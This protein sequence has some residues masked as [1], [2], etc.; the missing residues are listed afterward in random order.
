M[1]HA[2]Q[3][4][5]QNHYELYRYSKWLFNKNNIR[6]SV[7]FIY[8]IIV[9]LIGTLFR[10]NGSL[11]CLLVTVCFAIYLLYAETKKTYIKD[12]VVTARVKRQIV[13]LGL[14]MIAYIALAMHFMKEDLLGISVIAL[15]YLLIYPMA[16][17]TMPMEYLIKKHYENEARAIL[18]SQDD[19]LKIGI[20]GSY[21][22]TSTKNIINDIISYDRYTLMTPASYNTPMGITRTIRE[23]LKPIHEIFLCEMGADKVGDIS[24]LMDFVKP[25]YG[26]VTSIGKQHLNTFHDLEN[27]IYEK[28]QEVELLPPDGIAFLNA[29][30]E[31][32]RSYKIRN[33]CKVITVATADIEADYVA[34][35]LRYTKDGS[36]FTVKI[37][38]HNYKFTTSLLG[39]HNI[40]NILLGIAVAIELGMDLRTIQQRVRNVRQV[41]H[42]LQI[43]KISN[44]TF[45][46]DA[47]NANP[48]GSKNALDVLSMMPGKR[49]I[50]TP[51]MI[52][53]GTIQYDANK[54]F[55]KYMPGKADEVILVGEKQTEPIYA[56]LKEAAFDLAHVHVF[57]TVNEALTYVYKNFSSADTILLE[58][59]LPDAFNV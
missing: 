52:D 20:T 56:G 57:K 34:K 47:F 25:Q 14:L 12:L 50:V 22:K 31:Y 19:L 17:L 5:Q 21:G 28:M 9:L 37:N 13:V 15:S 43:K 35:D 39:K 33:R 11:L 24:Y 16:L 29:D 46:D 59:D 42:R 18:N 7:T 30:N 4:F 10:K 54:E 26:I 40:T 44:L 8:I 1:K 2:L 38:N 36:T 48:E 55:G 6:L 3:M 32:I 23:E 41:E 27:I 58:N 51:G 53:L 49:V 45:I